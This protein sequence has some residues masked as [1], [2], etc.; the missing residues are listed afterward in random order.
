MPA[1]EEQ[2]LKE[3]QLDYSE[4]VAVVEALKMELRQ[5]RHGAQAI[6]WHALAVAEHLGTKHRAQVV[7]GTV[8]PWAV[9]GQAAAYVAF[10]VSVS[11]GCAVCL[12][13]C[14]E[15]QECEQKEI[16]F[17][18]AAIAAN[19]KLQVCLLQYSVW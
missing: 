8:V 13:V 16:K 12:C 2:K 1:E 10:K 14:A 6:I 4:K 11:L 15:T 9:I 17:A 19:R 3:L 18:Q 7:Y 5:T